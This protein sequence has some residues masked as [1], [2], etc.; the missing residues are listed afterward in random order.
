MTYV[1]H[2]APDNASLIVRLA[3]E[4][5][6]IPYTAVLVDR[7][8]RAQDSE[9]YRALNP[10]GLIPVLETPQGPLFETAAI[11]LWLADTHDGL[12]PGPA[13]AERGGFLKWLFFL[14]NTPHA[15]M[16]LLFYS[17]RY[18]AAGH[19]DALRN[20]AASQI[21]HNLR[22]LDTLAAARPPWLAARDATVLDFYL[23]ALLRWLSLYP[24][25]GDRSWFRLSEYPALHDLCART[26]TLDC[27]ASV[28]AAEGLGPRPFTDPVPCTPPVGSAT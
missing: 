1:L 19:I 26:E 27:T 28:S 20:G 11:L 24:R 4:Y 23:C 10:A 5:R 15:L 7:A 22:I 25:D 18:V 12:G 21:A 16:R 13:A 9:A 2:F 3:L 6:A 8:A 17:D 14:S